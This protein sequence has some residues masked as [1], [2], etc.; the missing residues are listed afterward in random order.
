MEPNKEN[1][2]KISRKKFLHVCGS[3]I[4]GGSILGVSGV[5][6]KN[7]S[8][9]AVNSSSGK[10]GLTGSAQQLSNEA[11]ASPYKLV[12]SFSVPDKIDSF[13]ICE[14][15]LVVAASNTIYIYDKSGSLLNNF[16]VGSDVRDVAVANN[17]IYLLYPTRIET[18]D[19]DGEWIRE[20]EACSSESDYCQLA[21][22]P[23]FVFVTDAANKNI[24]K[25]TTE[26]NFV[27]FIQSPNGFIIPSYSFGIAY[28]DGVIYCSNSGRHQIE[29]Y[30]PE[31]EYI[32]AFGQ[33]GGASGLFCGCCNPVH[34]SFTSTGE[35]ITSEKGNPRISCY[36]QDG[37]FRSVLL[38]SKALGGGNMA[39]DVKVEKD[40]IFI[41]GKN[42][43]STFQ[44]DRVLAAATSCSGC[45]VDCPLREGILI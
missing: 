11:L 16:A 2:K 31:G 6:I 8:G 41:A 28:Q 38:D 12:S 1:S 13:E 21:V 26:G 33:A 20:W 30:T 34:L 9:R 10:K 18:Y 37:Q 36:G 7:R 44:Y 15:K 22:T 24:C 3:V 5:L 43:V 25:Y 35:I 39:Y 19:L 40:R 29:S 4:A 14:D 45:A 42:L 23:D 32:A 27:R 17:Q